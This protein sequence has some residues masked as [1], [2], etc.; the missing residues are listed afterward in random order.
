[1][2]QLL[3]VDVSARSQEVLAPLIGGDRFSRLQA[4]SD[5][6]RDR[7]A[8]RVVWNV[9]ST[10]AGGGVAEMLRFL[11]GYIRGDGVDARW[12]VMDGDPAF[13][14]ITKR[15]HNRIH[16]VQGDG[17]ALG[18]AEAA[19]YR[20]VTAANAA[21]LLPRVSPG[22]VVLLH[23]PQTSGL[24]PH[25]AQAQV[26]VV[27]RCH[28]GADRTNAWAEEAWEFLRPHLGLCDAFV[29]SRRAYAPAWVP[30][31]RLWVIAPSIDPF[32]PKN[33]P[34]PDAQ[35]P[36]FLSTMGLTSPQA[37]RARFTRADGTAGEVTRPATVVSEGPLDPDGAL[38]VQVSRWDHLKDMHGVMTGFASGV[39][40]PG[41][42]R[43]GSTGA[44]QLVLVGPSVEGVA[45]DPE[46]AAVLAQCIAS[47]EALP[48]RTR[49]RI[50]L[51][52]LPMVDVDENA[53]MVNALQRSAAIV[54]QKSLAEGFGLTVVEGMW[55]GK[56]VLASR[57]GG[58]VDQVVPGTGVLLD[59]PSDLDAYG[60]ALAGLLDRPADC[61]RM[62]DNAHRFVL[63]E[64]V[65]DRQLLQYAALLE[66]LLST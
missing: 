40:G 47:W 63:Q 3:D 6:S 19:H 66:H 42:R 53:A 21:A 61:A 36:L 45:D 49:R 2:A 8:G 12:V 28:I 34:I 37:G 55:K 11:V 22:D 57:V 7:L 50:R 31:E 41:D 52:T 25:L 24:A 64:F 58:I 38:V 26:K 1:M 65:G 60:D 10:A 14:A 18:P 43:V 51:V 56:P 4:V 16:G 9:N 62:G 54:V 32:S 30:A 44:A 5:A 17:G 46:G 15:I 27:W 39:V 33:Q 23:D 20:G 59:D 13:Y 35:L 29:F 48:L